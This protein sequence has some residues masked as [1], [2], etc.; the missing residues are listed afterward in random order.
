MFNPNTD[1]VDSPASAIR[2][3][4]AF[5]E[6]RALKARYFRFVDAKEWLALAD[7]FTEDA[8]F[9]RG[10]GGAVRNPMTGDWLDAQSPISEI[11]C[12]REAILAM[13]IDAIGDLWTIH[14]GSNAELALTGPTT[15]SGIWAMT[16]ELRDRSGNLILRG[17][18]YYEDT[19][20]QDSGV[21]RIAS[22]SLTRQFI[23]RSGDE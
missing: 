11:V 9:E 2:K 17:S 15:A 5:E 21:W 8:Q 13:V 18:G 3:L 16:D 4:I 1:P 22:S 23:E 7:L 14:R 20:Q 6:I 10:S 19:Y 12:G